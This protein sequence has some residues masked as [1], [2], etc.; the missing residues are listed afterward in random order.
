ED[1]FDRGLEIVVDAAPAATAPQTERPPVGIEHHLLRFAQIRYRQKHSRMAQAQ[2]RHLH[3]RRPPAQIDHLVTPVELI[4][5]PR[6]EALRDE[7]PAV[8]VTPLL[9]PRLNEPLYRR[10]RAAETRLHQSIM[11]PL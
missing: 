2:M 11:Q 9:A 1:Q 10:I 6:C 7:H 3:R 8:A 4:R 5:L